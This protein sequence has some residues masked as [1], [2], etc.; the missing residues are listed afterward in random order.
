[1]NEAMRIV[2]MLEES[3]WSDATEMLLVVADALHFG[4]HA[5]T[6]A[7]EGTPAGWRASSAEWREG[8]GIVDESEVVI[9]SSARTAAILPGRTI[10]FVA[11][12]ETALIEGVP[13]ICASGELA[14]IAGTSAKTTV[15]PP[16]LEPRAFV[17]ASTDHHRVL[18]PGAAHDSS[19]ALDLAYGAAL[20][21]RWSG[22]EFELVRMARW[23]PSRDE[24]LE[25]VNEYNVVATDDDR[26]RVIA[27]CDIIV[28]PAA[29]G[30]TISLA[31]LHAMASGLAP[32]LTPVGEYARLPWRDAALFAP[33]DGELLGDEL[34]RLLDDDDARISISRGARSAAEEFRTTRWITTLAEFV[35][36]L[37]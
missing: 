33:D 23:A 37:N 4:G 2:V 11:N 21:A 13:K 1:M 36:M 3:E 6:I 20:H 25:H 17:S 19:I 35:R 14:R 5:V 32:L 34:V 9:A 16:L 18:I 28:A 15:I 24:P 31:V 29:S 26:R 8:F 27:S 10:L 7:T 30:E 22:M 12:Q